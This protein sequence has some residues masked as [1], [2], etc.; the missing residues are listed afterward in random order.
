MVEML[1]FGSR[2]ALEEAVATFS[3]ERSVLFLFGAWLVFDSD[4]SVS[5]DK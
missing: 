3:R 5:S 1:D 4:F 2:V